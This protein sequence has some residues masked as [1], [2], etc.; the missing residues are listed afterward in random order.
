MNPTLSS[1][2]KLLI[3]HC[4]SPMRTMLVLGIF[5]GFF[6]PTFAE[7]SFPWPDRSG[8]YFNGQANPE[9]AKDLPIAWDEASGKNIAWKIPIEG[10]GHSTP[11]IGN[12]VAWL[13]SATKDGKEQFIYAIDTTSGKVIHHKKLFENAKPEELHNVINTYASPSCVLEPGAVYVHFGTYGTAKLNPETAEIVWERRDIECRHFR[14][15]GSSPV[16]FEDLLILTFDGIDKQFVM[17]LNK[18]T[19]ETVW[20]TPRS[21]DYKDLDSNGKPKGDGDYRKA[22]GTPGLVKAA[23]K[24]QVVSVGSRAAFGYDARTGKEIWTVTHDDY[25]AAARSFAYDGMAIIHT[26]S[27]GAN[28]MA[29]R[30]DEST[31]G[32]VEKSHIVWNRTRGNSRLASPILYQDRVY[33]ITEN[34]VA[35]GLNAKTGEELFAGRVKGNFVSSP[36]AANGHIYFCDERGQCTIIKAGDE[37]EI[38]QRNQ[39]AGG[40]RSSPAIAGG[41]LFLRTFNHLYKISKQK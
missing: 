14:G 15:P 27:R 39:L 41:A 28:L 29:I 13:T 7:E 1:L 21:T 16:I 10:F 23:G 38:V 4:A 17:A 2:P 5:V 12:G 24:T 37:F 6:K 34:G 31:K 32:N 8:P 11:V 18:K 3:R 36:V 26:G 25:N 35:Y 30:L 19:G 20:N 9:E 33:L 40:M 22:Y